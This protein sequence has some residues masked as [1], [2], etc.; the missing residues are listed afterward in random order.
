MTKNLNCIDVHH[1]ITPAFYVDAL[2]SIGITKSYG[3][4][5]PEWTPAT[6]LAYMKTTGIGKAILS[7]TTQE[8]C[9]KN[10]PVSKTLTRICNDYLARVKKLYP[11]KFGGFAS[12]PML[13]PE[14][15][16]N[17]LHHAL[18]ELQLDGVILMT[19]YDCKY[20]GHNNFDAIF[21]ELNKRKTTVFIHPSDTLEA[22]NSKPA[23]SNGLIETTFETT[24]TVANLIYTETLQ[25]YPDIRWILA[26]GGGNIPYISWRLSRTGHIPKNKNRPVMHT[27]YDFLA[28]SGPEKA[29]SLMQNIYYD[30][31]LNRNGYMY[32]ALQDY[33]EPSHIVFGTDFPMA[34][35]I[36]SDKNQGKSDSHPEQVYKIINNNTCTDITYTDLN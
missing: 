6:S 31:A 36:V 32:R 3:Q 28:R 9:L 27:L 33:A 11:G 4:S 21:R 29:L 1:H 23:I 26:H 22:Y 7:F 14:A 17:E 8:I 34:K 5:F 24:R 20:L 30:N 12:L 35:V 18:D 16:L 2:K 10:N 13:C 19:S 25:R 15:A